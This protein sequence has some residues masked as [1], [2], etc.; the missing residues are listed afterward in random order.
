V[1]NKDTQ[2]QTVPK[3][4]NSKNLVVL[5]RV[6]ENKSVLGCDEK[7]DNTKHKEATNSN[8]LEMISAIPKLNMDPDQQVRKIS[9]GPTIISEEGEV[10]NDEDSINDKTGDQADEEDE[11]MEVINAISSICMWGHEGCTIKSHFKYDWQAENKTCLLNKAMEQKDSITQDNLTS[12]WEQRAKA[13][14]PQPAK[15]SSAKSRPSTTAAKKTNLN[16]GLGVKSTLELLKS[17]IAREECK[18][19]KEKMLRNREL[20]KMKK[21]RQAGVTKDYTS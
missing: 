19:D 18:E 17:R 5:N 11:V 3:E 6:E 21:L 16:G 8:D 10:N 1:N 4:N 15:T 13:S 7:M 20:D 9:A 12:L 2:Q 14:Q